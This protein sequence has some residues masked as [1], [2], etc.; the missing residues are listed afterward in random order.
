[1]ERINL[2]GEV[3]GRLIVIAEA[4]TANK[5]RR[6]LCKCSCGAEKVIALASLRSG[7]TK[8]CGCFH[9]EVAAERGRRNVHTPEQKEAA[10]KKRIRLQYNRH[11]KAKFGISVEAA[12]NMRI[13]QDDK[14]AICNNPF[15]QTP[16]LDHD[17]KTGKIRGLLCHPCNLI[18]GLAKDNP[19]ILRN[20][21][22]YLEVA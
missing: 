11:L 21:T 18:L 9:K 1:M 16:D 15:T 8:S 19:D 14:C 12:D 10:R 3:F 17:H 7:N 2:I 22:Y 13:A 5:H 6:L 4:P 20:A